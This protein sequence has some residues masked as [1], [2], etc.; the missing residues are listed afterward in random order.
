MSANPL[1]FL[2]T[3]EQIKLPTGGDFTPSGFVGQAFAKLLYVFMSQVDSQ[4][5]EYPDLP[6]Y[7]GR[8]KAGEWGFKYYYPT[9]ASAKAA[10][11][12]LDVR[13]QK[14]NYQNPQTTW[15]TRVNRDTVLNFADADKLAKFPN[16]IVFDVQVSTLRAKRRHEFHMLALPFAVQA[17]ANL[18]GYDHAPFTAQILRDAERR[19]ND[20]V[21]EAV[22]KGTDKAEA[23]SD[24]IKKVFDDELHLMA[25]GSDK[26]YKGSELWKER[27]A[28]W[29]SL[30]EKN[31]EAYMPIGS[32]KSAATSEKLSQCLQIVTAPWN[33]PVW[34]RVVQLP[35]PRTDARYERDGETKKESIGVLYEIFPSKKEAE[36]AAAQDIERLNK[37]AASNSASNGH[38][39]ESVPVPAKWIA[40]GLADAWPTQVVTLREQYPSKPAGPILNKLARTNDATVEEIS[41]IWA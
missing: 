32:E 17:T 2:N 16:P 4:N 41:A 12:M 11:E 35:D 10:I 28:L 25:I 9:F 29:E 23:R 20:I 8:T 3:N 39:V 13:D 19:V 38:S 27:I 14:G 15:S 6:K 34:A 36:L 1:S 5:G 31:A 7:E 33:A 24:A 26:E 18:L 22:A 21:S 40:E 37:N 30:G